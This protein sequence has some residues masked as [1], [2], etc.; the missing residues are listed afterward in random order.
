MWGPATPFPRVVRLASAPARTAVTGRATRRACSTPLVASLQLAVELY[1]VPTRPMAEID[2]QEP[3]DA[4]R[5]VE[6][7][8]RTGSGP[9]RLDALSLVVRPGEIY[10]ILGAAGAGKSQVLHAFLGVTS[11]AAGRVLVQ[12]EDVASLGRAVRQRVTYIPKGSPLYGSLSALRNVQFLTCADGRVAGLREADC[13]NAMR[14]MGVPERYFDRPARELGSAVAL[15]LWLAVGFLKD[16]PILLIDEPTAGLD[17]Y[18]SAD[19]QECLRDFAARAKAVLIATSDVLLAGAV[20]DR[21]GILKEG[22]KRVELTRAELA[23]RSLP[24]LYLEYM[25]RSLAPM[26]RRV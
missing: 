8:Q 5:A 3:G 17:L 4:L 25:G 22:R 26:A 1:L 24:Q 18:A 12:G 23:G 11:P 20:S 14:R 7:S 10:S 9:L 13:L 19:L 6:L 2:V 15:G 21:V 16:S